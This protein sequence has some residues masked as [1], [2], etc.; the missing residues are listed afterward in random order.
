MSESKTVKIEVKNLGPIAG[1][2]DGRR[3]SITLDGHEIAHVLKSF[4]VKSNVGE[5]VLVEME[6]IGAE[7][8]IEGLEVLE[9]HFESELV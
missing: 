8:E 4:S 1:P 2:N 6:V 9:E 3:P 5:S 7:V